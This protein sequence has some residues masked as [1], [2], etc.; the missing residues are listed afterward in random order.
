MSL[1]VCL[2]VYVATSA[3]D[4]EIGHVLDKREFTVLILLRVGAMTPAFVTVIVDWYRGRWVET[5]LRKVGVG[6][7]VM[8]P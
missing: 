3:L 2:C 7:G 6:V 5:W 1:C 4:L 8:N